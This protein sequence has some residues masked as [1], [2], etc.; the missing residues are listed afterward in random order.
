MRTSGLVIGLAGFLFVGAS[1]GRQ[2]AKITPEPSSSPAFANSPR[3]LS[4]HPIA[5]RLPAANHNKA[6]ISTVQPA[7]PGIALD[8]L[9]ELFPMTVS[10]AVHHPAYARRIERFK[11]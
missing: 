7:E 1:D 6:E 4:S 10:R 9:F 8:E 11:V 2:P 5:A 3:N